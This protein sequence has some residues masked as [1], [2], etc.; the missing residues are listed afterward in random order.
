MNVRERLRPQGPHVP[1]WGDVAEQVWLAFRL[2]RCA[3]RGHD[4]PD[5]AQFCRRCKWFVP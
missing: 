1:T 5:G 3:L 2:A 4:L